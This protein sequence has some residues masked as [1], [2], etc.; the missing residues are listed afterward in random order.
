MSCQTSYTYH[1][2]GFCMSEKIGILKDVDNLGRLVI[3]KEF[4]ERF[5]LRKTVELVV[6]AEGILLKSPE[7]KLVKTQDEETS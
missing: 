3:P 7:Y 4:R 5:G 1:C 2:G 6:T